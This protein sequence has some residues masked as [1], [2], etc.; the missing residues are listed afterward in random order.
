[1]TKTLTSKGQVTIPKA[2]RDHLGIA[3]GSEVNFR[4]GDNGDVVIERADGE[5]PTGRFASL[6]GSAG[7]GMST[8]ELMALLRGEPE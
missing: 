8:D 2:V 6:R 5:K 7:P 4:L 3:P 1:M